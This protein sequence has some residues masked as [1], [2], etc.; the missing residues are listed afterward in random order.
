MPVHHLMNN[1]FPTPA[2]GLIRQSDLEY[3]FSF[4]CLISDFQEV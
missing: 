3:S 4:W 2:A 1:S